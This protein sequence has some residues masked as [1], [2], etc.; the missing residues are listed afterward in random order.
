MIR[1]LLFKATLFLAVLM[2]AVGCMNNDEKEFEFAFLTDIHVTPGSANAENLKLVVEEINDSDA[3]MVIITGDI[4]NAGSDAELQLVKGILDQLTKHYL[5][6]PGNHETNWSESAGLSIIDLWDDDRFIV[7]WNDFV[8]VGLSTGPFMKMGDGHV[9]QEDIQWLKSELDARMTKKKKLL[10]FAH[11]PLADGLDNWSDVTSVLKENNCLAV[12]CGHGHRLGLHNFD[13]IPG[14]MGRAL[15][16][17][18]PAAAGY[19]IVEVRSDSIFVN[20]KLLGDF[21][22]MPAI[23]FNY[24]DPVEISGLPI[25]PKPDFSI[26]EQYPEIVE[27]FL[28]SDTASIFSGVCLVGDSMFIY[29]NSLGW[30]KAVNHIK[31]RSEWEVKF[32]GPVFSSPSF[33]NNV[34]VFGA[35]DGNIYGLDVRN[36]KTIWNVDCGTPVLASP[37]IEDD[38]VYIGGGKNAFYSINITNGEVRWT[39]NEIDGLIQGRATVNGDNVVFGAWDRHLYCLSAS[40]GGLKWKWSNGKPNDLLSPG[41]IVPAISNNRVYIVAPDRFMTAIDLTSGIEVWRTNKHQVRESMGISPDG[42]EIFAKLMNDSIISVSAST[43]NFQTNW[44]VDAGIKYDHNPC[45]LLSDQ[46][47]VIGAT[48]NGLITAIDRQKQNVAWMHKIGNSSINELVF[49][50]DGNLWFSSI[51]GKIVRLTTATR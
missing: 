14:I 48:K 40:T 49:D 47:Y 20:E 26:N 22:A 9:K 27:S 1:K 46:K 51:E 19:N 30:L 36:G 39:F 25:S 18:N 42:E 29:A 7:E 13:G 41:N 8:L 43:R 50:R 21:S 16:Q 33:S 45:P 5:I 2:T 23:S 44:A 10:A 32:Q 37:S 38:F 24:T 12:F 3:D 17:G 4:S 35:I 31:N 15:M 6:I 34:V 28:W 11:Y